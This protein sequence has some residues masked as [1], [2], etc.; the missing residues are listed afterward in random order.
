MSTDQLHLPFSPSDLSILIFFALAM[1]GF[2]GMCMTFT[3]LTV[4]RTA[5]TLQYQGVRLVVTFTR[6]GSLEASVRSTLTR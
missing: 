4:S 5:L 6:S 1:N 2:G 3:S